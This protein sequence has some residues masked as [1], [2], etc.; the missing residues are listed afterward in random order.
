MLLLKQAAKLARFLQ[1]SQAAKPAPML[2]VVNGNNIVWEVALRGRQRDG[3]INAIIVTIGDDFAG[4]ALCSGHA[5][6]TASVG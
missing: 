5:R 3:H 4:D 2:S 1:G 6:Q